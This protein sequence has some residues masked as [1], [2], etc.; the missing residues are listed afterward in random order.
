MGRKQE[1]LRKG[2]DGPFCLSAITRLADQGDGAVQTGEA[3]GTAAIA[4]IHVDV[5]AIGSGLDCLL[6][7]GIFT[8]QAV[9][10]LAGLTACLD[11][12]PGLYLTAKLQVEAPVGQALAQ[13]PQ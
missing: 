12:Y 10:A 4:G 13:L 7:A 2:P 1:Q 6:G 5:D 8:E 11:P 9:E 3:T